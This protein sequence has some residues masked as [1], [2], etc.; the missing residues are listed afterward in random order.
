MK[1]A[2]IA[3]GLI[4]SAANCVHLSNPVVVAPTADRMMDLD[5]QMKVLDDQISPADE[6]KALDSSLDEITQMKQS[7]MDSQ[8]AEE[9]FDMVTFFIVYFGLI[10][11]WIFAVIGFMGICASKDEEKKTFMKEVS[12]QDKPL[13][14][15]DNTAMFFATLNVLWQ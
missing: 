6:L 10:F 9:F 8:A 4:F 7:E 11:F 15:A 2:L 12:K 1:A 5:A 13:E 14:Y 3:F